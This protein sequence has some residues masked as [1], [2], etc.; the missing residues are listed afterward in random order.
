MSTASRRATFGPDRIRVR[1]T[2]TGAELDLECHDRR[3]VEAVLSALL[4]DHLDTFDEI[5]RQD[6]P[7]DGHAAE[8]L[9]YERLV[10]QL[11]KALPKNAPLYGAEVPALA[12]ELHEIARPKA[13]PGQRDGE[14]AA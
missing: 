13:L 12:D 5:A 6:Q 10:E 1:A 9:L 8:R 3:T 7:A 14:A 2:T 11:V 4:E